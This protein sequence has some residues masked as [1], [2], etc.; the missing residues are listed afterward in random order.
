MLIDDGLLHREDERWV[1]GDELA[2]L[3]VPPTIH[4]LL[5]ARLERLPEEERALLAR[6]SVEGTVFH[7]EVDARAR[8]G[9]TRAARGPEPHGARP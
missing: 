9:R 5:A 7:R 2:E 1:L 6:V 3:P 4:A 8:A